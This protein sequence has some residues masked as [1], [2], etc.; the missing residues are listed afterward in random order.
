MLAFDVMIDSVN[1]NGNMF[2]DTIKDIYLTL[3]LKYPEI[4]MLTGYSR[5]LLEIGRIL[6][7]Q[8]YYSFECHRQDASQQ[9][10]DLMKLATSTKEEMKM[11]IKEQR[12]LFEFFSKWDTTKS[13]MPLFD[14]LA[15]VI[16]CN[17]EEAS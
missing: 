9:S 17:L 10:A 14:A 5:R 12:C 2:S 8:K 6:K 3:Y 15:S 16:G 1:E 11:L 7:N 13:M 4:N